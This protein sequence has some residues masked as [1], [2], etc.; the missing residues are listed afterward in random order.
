M[1]MMITTEE[2]VSGCKAHTKQRPQD[3]CHIFFY[4]SVIKKLNEN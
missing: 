3:L 1:N 2:E 4:P